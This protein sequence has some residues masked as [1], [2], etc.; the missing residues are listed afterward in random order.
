MT[1]SR[2][3]VNRVICGEYRNLTRKS[4]RTGF[5]MNYSTY[6]LCEQLVAANCLAFLNLVKYKIENI[7]KILIKV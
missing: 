6:W 2:S 5:E 3:S 7:T 4:S 1:S